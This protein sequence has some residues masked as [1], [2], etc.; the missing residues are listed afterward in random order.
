MGTPRVPESK[1]D[2]STSDAEYIDIPK[3]G[4]VMWVLLACFLIPPALVTYLG[5]YLVPI[6]HQ[7][8]WVILLGCP[9]PVILLS[10]P[11]KYILD[12]EKLTI[13]GLFYRIRV[14][15]DHVVKIERITTFKA[16]L[17]PGSIYCADPQRAL[18]L[19]RTKGRALVISPTEPDRFLGL[20]KGDES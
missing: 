2:P 8:L 17:H 9:F 19:T 13:S 18:M 10:L 11:R 15:Y 6:P 1:P 7:M 3:M 14:P 20:K 5:N 4:S 12:Q 16:L